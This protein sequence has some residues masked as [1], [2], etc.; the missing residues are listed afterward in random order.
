M[1]YLLINGDSRRLPIDLAAVDAVVTDPP[2]GIGFMGKEWDSTRGGRRAWVAWLAECLAECLRVAKPGAVLLCWA[3]PRTS[4]WTGTAIEDAGWLIEDRITHHFGSGFPKH[5]SKL[6][7]ATEDWWLARK[8]GAKW[9]GVDQCRVPAPEGLTSGGCMKPRT[10]SVYAQDP[11]TMNWD[12]PRSEEHPAGRWPPNLVLSHLP[13]CNGECVEGCPVRLMGE[14]GGNRKSGKAH[15]LHRRKE[16]QYCGGFR[17]GDAVDALYGDEGSAAR[18]FPQFD[19]DP[20][21]YCTKASQSDRGSGNEHPTVKSLALMRWLCRLACPKGGVILD[22]FAGSGS[23]I[24]AALA[25]GHRAIGIEIDSRY[26]EIAR[27]RLEHP[28]AVVP[29]PGKAEF[30][31]LFGD[32]P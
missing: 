4:H 23:T 16:G 22:P 20:F 7:P 3:I 6:K 12:K 32:A 27:R 13:D 26:C 10:R 30:H 19:A 25:E 2:A 11:W 21:L 1:G 8:P 15:V 9:L 31:P 17:G 24:I 18:F 14:Q 28:H 29:R 5:Q